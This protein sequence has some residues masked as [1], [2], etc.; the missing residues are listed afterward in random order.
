V[1]LTSVSLILAVAL[2]LLGCGAVWN[3]YDHKVLDLFHRRAVAHGLGPRQS[4]RVVI[5]AISDK[6]YD[7]FGKNTLDRSYVASLNQALAQLNVEALAYDLIF[8]RP[9]DPESDAR[10]TASLRGLGS[11]YLPIGLAYSE[12]AAAF[13]WEEGRAYE[14]FRSDYLRKPLEI[15]LGRPYYATRALMQADDFAN[16]A[17]NSG[18]IS[19]FSDPDG[20]YRHVIMLLKVG[21]AYFPTLSL[22]MFLD[23]ARVPFENLVV[24]WGRRIIIPAAREG[25]LEQEVI[26]PI[27]DRGRAFI[28]FPQVWDQSFKIRRPSAIHGR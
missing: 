20:V 24:E 5:I 22:S 28:P 2:V 25:F 4:P 17:R 18:H 3:E 14:K 10:F 7:F 27:D 21:D 12:N 26:I 19:A 8:A 11:V 15:G 1:G 16:A 23:Y 13:R 6:T 9:S